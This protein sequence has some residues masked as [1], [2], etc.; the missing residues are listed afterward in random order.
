MITRKSPDEIER[1]REAGEIVAE[2][3]ELCRSMAN[4]GVTTEEMDAEAEAL[5]RRRNGIP[6]FKG[7]RGYPKTICASI[8][9]EVVHGI[10]GPRKLEAGQ[11]LS[12]DVGVKLAGY[13]ADAAVTCPVGR[14]PEGGEALAA[15]CGEALKRATACL[16]AGVK[17]STVCRTIQTYVE[18][19]GY[20]V[21][22]RY[23]G[24]GIGREMHEEPQVPN[25]FTPA[26][27]DVILPLGAVL[28]LEPMINAGRAEVEVL[29]NGWTVVTKDRSL[30][31]HFEHT[32]AVSESGP[33]VLTVKRT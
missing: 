27:Q 3:L 14:W 22:R 25:F 18:S 32:V 20:S 12:V 4:P 6:L 33:D 7:Y 31:A 30:S 28:A 17:L 5:I 9:E 8:D 13:C 26:M 29:G 24:H 23:T 1:M 21:V 2:T 11:L 15:A 19:Q 16:R 10:P